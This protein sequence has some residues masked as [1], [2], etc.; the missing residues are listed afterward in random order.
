MATSTGVKHRWKQK[1]VLGTIAEQN[2]FTMSAINFEGGSMR[3]I[4]SLEWNGKTMEHGSVLGM[5]TFHG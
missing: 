1:K 4:S 5:P 3:V 2:W